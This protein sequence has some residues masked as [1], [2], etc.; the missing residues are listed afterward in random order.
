MKIDYNQ[1]LR[2]LDNVAN[3]GSKYELKRIKLLCEAL[4]NP[5][6]NYTIIH[7]TGTKGKGSVGAI[8]S[9]LLSKQISTGFFSSPH[10]FDITER[11]R[12]NNE[13]ISKIDF[14]KNLGEIWPHILDIEKMTGHKPS[15]FE[16]LTALAFYSFYKANLKLAI[17]EVGLG[18]RLDATNIADGKYC[19]FTRIHYDH[20]NILG[21]TLCDI[22]KEKAGIIKKNSKVIYI[23][24]EREVVNE[25]KKKAKNMHAHLYYAPKY[26]KIEVK[27][28]DLFGQTIDI[29][30]KNN[31]RLLNVPFPLNGKHQIENLKIALITMLLLYKDNII[32]RLPL[33]DEF[34]NIKWPGRLEIKKMDPP[35]I[36][37]GAHNQISGIRLF[38]FLKA[39]GKG[40]VFLIG[41]LRDKD[42]TN[43]LNKIV[44]LSNAIVFT[45]VDSHRKLD[46]EILRDTVLSIK[47]G[48]NI[49]TEINNQRAYEIA[50]DIAKNM[51]IPLVV[52]GSL[53]LI[54]NIKY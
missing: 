32:K 36:I 49:I 33:A 37:D 4:S 46:V 7:I 1:A 34:R 47:K 23:N 35:V 19:V 3:S 50:L 40:Y 18:G 8:L 27:H 13:N 2:L 29:Y 17:I 54:G 26:F 5:E 20:T 31:F 9:G 30:G 44:H 6:K 15:Y 51:K 48:I 24:R 22:A 12:I 42:Y 43:F 21:P 14:T 28:R 52:T 10:I 41:M 38:E 16:T 45:E 53:Y 11:I 25:I 39:H